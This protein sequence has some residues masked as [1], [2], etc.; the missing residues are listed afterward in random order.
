MAGQEP[1]GQASR[2]LTSAGRLNDAPSVF[3][4]LSPPAFR[5]KAPMWCLGQSRSS[6]RNPAMAW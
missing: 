4:P 2:L 5:G 1:D 6:I 3:S